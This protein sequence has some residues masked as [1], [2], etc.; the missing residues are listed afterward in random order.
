MIAVAVIAV[1]GLAYSSVLQHAAD[2][3]TPKVT[4]RDSSG[5]VIKSVTLGFASPGSVSVTVSFSCS[6]NAGPVTLRF[7]SS[8]E[9]L[10]SLSQTDFPSCDSSLNS[11]TLSVHSTMSLNTAGN[12]HATQPDNYRTLAEPLA[13]EV[14]VT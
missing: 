12:L 3:S 11:V 14:N 10:V 4:W 2:P 13:V 1:G 9:S 7:S 6:Q 5:T 8:L